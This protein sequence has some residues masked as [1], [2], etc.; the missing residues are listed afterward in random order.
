MCPPKVGLKINKEV[1]MKFNREEKR[2][3]VESIISKRKSIV[4]I[5]KEFGID[6]RD[7]KRLI[8]L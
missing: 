8:A 5:S 2:K 3:M 7:L 4:S 1:C 6:Y